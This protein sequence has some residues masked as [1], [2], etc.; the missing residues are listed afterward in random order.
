LQTPDKSAARLEMITKPERYKNSNLMRAG[1]KIMDRTQIQPIHIN[2]DLPLDLIKN[3]GNEIKS[4][5]RTNNGPNSFGR[6]GFQDDTKEDPNF[7]AHMEYNMRKV[8]RRSD[9]STTLD[10]AKSVMEK[11]AAMLSQQANLRNQVN[12]TQMDSPKL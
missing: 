10:N 12:R 11:Q 4:V 1:N 8:P 3:F 9:L 2:K 5:K 7:N 6:L